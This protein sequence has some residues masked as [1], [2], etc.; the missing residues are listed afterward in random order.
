MINKE[1]LKKHYHDMIK[2][3]SVSGDEKQIGKYIK[4]R[5][6]E[7]G[8][9][10][11]MIYFEEGKDRP[12]VYTSLKSEKPGPSI[13]LIGHIDTVGINDEWDTDPFQPVE[14]GKKTYGR[15]A[16]DMK[17]GLSAI[18]E[19]LTYFKNN[20]DEFSGEIIAAFVSDEEVLAKGTYRLLEEDISPEMAIMAECRFDNVAVGFRGRYSIEIDVEGQSAHSSKYPEIGDNAIISAGKLAAEIENLPT[21]VHPKL[22]EGSWCVKYIEGGIQNALIVPNKC[23][24]VLERFFV[25]GE[26]YETIEK[27]IIEAA[28]KL[29]IKEKTK[30]K[31]KERTMPYMEPFTIPEDDEL[32]VKLTEKYKEV[33]GNILKMEYD[34]SVCDSNILVNSADIKTV[35]FGPSGENMHGKN[36]F[37]YFHQVLQSTEIYIKT[38]KELLK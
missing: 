24:I 38:L 35:T 20:S 30:V 36:E 27:Q 34:K 16:M 37:G 11:K 4:E 12:S 10:A 19:T 5:I 23:H 31:L 22:G 29:G 8:L 33:T 9:E 14:K 32:V 25:E 2:I 26:T 3:K 18:I 21:V 28:E 15:G 7:I 6:E 13:L 17:G 1:R